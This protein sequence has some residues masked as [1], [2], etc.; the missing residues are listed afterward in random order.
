MRRKANKMGIIASS[1]INPEEKKNVIPERLEEITDIPMKSESKGPKKALKALGLLVLGTALY[2]AGKFGLDSYNSEKNKAEQLSK[3]NKYLAAEVQK[4][5]GTYVFFKDRCQRLEESNKNLEGKLKDRYTIDELLAI[6]DKTFYKVRYKTFAKD[7]GG[8]KDTLLLMTAGVNKTKKVEDDG[9]KLLYCGSRNR[10]G[11][12]LNEIMPGKWAKYHQN[13]KSN[14]LDIFIFDKEPN[15]LR[16]G[17]W[18]KN[19]FITKYK[20]T[21]NNWERDSIMDY[22]RR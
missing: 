13:Y 11:N 16:I 3:E 20:I 7:N 22:L 10:I 14:K 6:F 17:N 21:L 19:D 9:Y 4:S 1:E 8:L 18:K 2:M 15:V 5:S 12:Y